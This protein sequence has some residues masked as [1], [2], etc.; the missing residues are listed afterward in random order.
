MKDLFGSHGLQVM[1]LAAYL[2]NK[3][4]CLLAGLFF[5]PI[6]AVVEKQMTKGKKPYY[7]NDWPLETVVSENQIDMWPDQKPP[8]NCG[9]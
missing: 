1:T 2:L 9:L 8:C 6:Q 7:I 4:L 3:V 5:R